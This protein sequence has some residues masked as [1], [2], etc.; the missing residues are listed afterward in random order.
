M[1][2]LATIVLPFYKVNA[3]DIKWDLTEKYQQTFERIKSEITSQKLLA[4]YRKDLPVNKRVWNVMSLS[5]RLPRKIW[6]L[7]YHLDNANQ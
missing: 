6:G 5:Y 2:S 7:Y 1:K 4:K 3:N